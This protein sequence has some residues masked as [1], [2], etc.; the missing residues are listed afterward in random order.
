MGGYRMSNI[1]YEFPDKEPGDINFKILYF[2]K[3]EYEKD[4]HST[5][6]FH[7]FLELLYV[8]DGKGN[9]VIDTGSYALEKGDLV[10]INP[11]T[12][13]TETS[14]ESQPLKY[15]IIG[16]ENIKIAVNR[17]E[18]EE[19][20]R[21]FNPVFHDGPFTEKIIRYLNKVAQELEEKNLYSSEIAYHRLCWLFIS[22]LRANNLKLAPNTENKNTTKEILFVKQYIDQHYAFNITIDEL[23]QKAFINKYHL[24]HFFTQAYGISPI[25]YLNQRR[26]QEA[27][28]L[29]RTT[30][31]SV[32]T[33]ANAVGFASPA[34]F[35]KKFKELNEMSPKDYRKNFFKMNDTKN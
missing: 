14:S 26:I 15:Y 16:V 7:P 23:A 28:T 19:K 5:A 33:I 27:K 32:T 4:W 11:Y 8:Y 17:S 21:S 1:R 20:E 10:I 9:F 35:A 6:H 2:T 30:D 25:R 31:L 12:I 24:V 13:H 18:E 29:L 22:F 34:F 3:S